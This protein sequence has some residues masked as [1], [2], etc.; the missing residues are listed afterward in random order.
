MI[1]EKINNGSLIEETTLK[2]IKNAELTKFVST[3]AKIY[4]NNIFLTEKTSPV[5]RLYGLH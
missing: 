5:K 1:A 3:C 4:M 2:H